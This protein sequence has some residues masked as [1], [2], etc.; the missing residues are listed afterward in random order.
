MTNN[1]AHCCAPLMTIDDVAAYLVVP[2]ATVY[3]WRSRG[4]GPAGHRVGKY[5]RYR[6]TDVDAWLADQAA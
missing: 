2:V 3:A 4:Q 5:V 6:R 1:D